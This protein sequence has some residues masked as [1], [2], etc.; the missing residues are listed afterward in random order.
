[1]RFFNVSGT[2][3]TGYNGAT[4][5]IW[6]A[7]NDYPGQLDPT[8]LYHAEINILGRTWTRYMQV[9]YSEKDLKSVEYIRKKMNLLIEQMKKELADR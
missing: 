9:E 4:S 3:I 7:S 5:T 2:N 6:V 8:T 1:M